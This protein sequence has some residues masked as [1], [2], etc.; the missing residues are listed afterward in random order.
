MSSSL[1]TAGIALFALALQPYEAVEPH[2]GTL[3]RIKLYAADEEQ[4]QAAFRAA[5]TRIAQLDDALSDYQPD[6]ELNHLCR[7]AVH[8]PVQVSDDLLKVLAAS[9]ELS[10]ESA[11]AFDVTIGPLTHLWRAA[12]KRNEVPTAEEVKE[13][14]I[15]CGYRNLHVDASLRTVKLD[16]EGMQLDLGAIAKGYAADAALKLISDCG[17][18]SALVA[19]SGDLA[20]SDAPPGRSGWKVGIDSY[21]RNDAPFTRT[22]MLANAAVSTS[23][24]SEQHV[25]AGG[26]RY[27]H[28]I[29]PRTGIGLTED[30]AVTVVARRG[31]D[32]DPMATAISVLGPERGMALLERRAGMSVLIMSKQNG[33]PKLIQSPS[34]GRF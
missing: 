4:A 9:E 22:L 27:S 3:F 29:D 33:R 6:S 31:L 15:R 16:L 2:M 5:F 11:G 34:F 18:R 19:A 7:S 28:I 13:A 14:K 24:P 12:R 1:L 17:I 21:D 8:R 23:G 26:I 30:I 25:D 32:A 20:F 10:Q